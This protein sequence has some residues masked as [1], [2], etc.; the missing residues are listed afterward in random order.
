MSMM[1]DKIK[2]VVHCCK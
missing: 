1:R 2:P